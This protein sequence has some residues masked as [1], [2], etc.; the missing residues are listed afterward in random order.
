VDAALHIIVAMLQ[1]LLELGETKITHLYVVFL[2]SSLVPN[3]LDQFK[4]CLIHST[5]DRGGL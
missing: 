5:W 2:S 1:I 4:T 3:I